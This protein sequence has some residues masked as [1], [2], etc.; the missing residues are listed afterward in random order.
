VLWGCGSVT[1]AAILFAGGE[2]TRMGRPKALLPWG[3]ATLIEYQ[4]RELHAAGFDEIVV[5]LGHAAGEF[6]PHVPAKARVVVNEAY[7]EGRASSLRVA[8]SALS[9]EADPI[10]VL[11]IDQPRPRRVHEW[12]LSA[13]RNSGT[14]ITVP[15]SHGRRG[16]PAVVAGSLLSELRNAS[17]RKHGLRGIIAAH[18]GDVR[19]VPVDSPVIFLNI[20]TPEEY[21]RALAQFAPGTSTA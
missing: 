4:V 6:R 16:H 10:V 20:N 8:A 9:D 15:T 12:L 14:L 7:R 19:E 5:V 2:S 3:D 11:S 17:E 18:D 13:H 1:A 21:E